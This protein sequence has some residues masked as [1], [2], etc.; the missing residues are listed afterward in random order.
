M[1]ARALIL[2]A[3]RIARDQGHS[4]SS[5]SRKSGHAFNGQTISRIVSKGDCRVSTFL[6]LLEPL[7]YKL[8]LIKEEN[9]FDD[10]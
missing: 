5:W 3:D 1:D 9:D 8:A 7:G 6:D 2:L 4:Q 10:E